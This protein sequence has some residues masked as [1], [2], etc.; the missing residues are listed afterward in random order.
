MSLTVT[1]HGIS[2]LVERVLKSIIHDTTNRHGCQEGDLIKENRSDVGGRLRRE[3]PRERLCSAQ[4]LALVAH[5][6]RD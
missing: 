3:L 6:D 4:E 1:K 5:Q 2:T